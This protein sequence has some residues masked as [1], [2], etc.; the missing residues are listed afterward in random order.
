MQA[1]QIHRQNTHEYNNNKVLIKKSLEDSITEFY[2]IFKECQFFQTPEGIIPNLWGQHH[3]VS[4]LVKDMTRKLAYYECRCNNDLQTRSSNRKIVLVAPTTMKINYCIKLCQ[5]T[6]TKVIQSS[7]LM[8][9]KRKKHATKPNNRLWVILF[10]KIGTEG[11]FL[12]LMKCIYK[13]PQLSQARRL[14]G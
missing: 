11:N 14:S 10:K 8:L 12:N 13:N 3:F 5:C 4:K 7:L 2:S 9:K 6:K 1:A